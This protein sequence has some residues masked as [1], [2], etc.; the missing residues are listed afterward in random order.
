MKKTIKTLA[1]VAGFA[2]IAGNA[3]AAPLDINIYGASA[4]FA[5]LTAA[6]DNVLTAL[7]C[8]GTA[9]R[10]LVGT[11]FA[12]SGTPGGTGSCANGIT[13]RIANKSSGDGIKAVL[14]TASG[15][16]CASNFQRQFFTSPTNTALLC[17]NVTLAA[18]DVAPGTFNEVTNG[19]EFG[20]VRDTATSGFCAAPTANGGKA[21]TTTTGQGKCYLDNK[22][23]T[24]IVASNV[25]I[26]NPMIV[27]FAIFANN[28]LQV[29]KCNDTANLGRLCDPGT[30][31]PCATK[32]NCVAGPLD[33]L[34]RIQAVNIF[35]NAVQDLTDFGTAYTSSSATAGTKIRACIRHAGSGTL[36]TL[37]QTVMNAGKWG[38]TLTTDNDPTCHPFTNP[39]TNTINN[40]AY[41]A[42]LQTTD[43]SDGFSA[44]WFTSSAD[45]EMNCINSLDNGIGFVD[46]DACNSSG[47]NVSPYTIPGQNV[48]N[49]NLCSNLHMLAYNG[50]KPY[51][52]NVRNGAYELFTIENL[53]MNNAQYAAGSPEATFFANMIS[54]IK[55]SFIST[56]NVGDSASYWT[57]V[58]EMRFTKSA[59]GAFPSTIGDTVAPT[60][61]VAP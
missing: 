16:G 13:L 17:Q 7:G 58:A 21:C 36:S 41:P 26:K 42:C 52:E 14:G 44:T 48:Y 28:T 33:N 8:A 38:S 32:A 57:T 55:P 19:C 9:N 27:P 6:A 35:S 37:N 34:S 54:A 23:A 3:Q 24:P 43:G 20:P 11:Q 1:V 59:D 56:G 4:Q 45:D 51:R 5:F 18:S 31:A 29:S 61:P 50:T 60:A 39:P 40:P 2:A 30:G 53:V 12:I 15:N 47:L 10:T 46:A 22:K 25:T 49:T